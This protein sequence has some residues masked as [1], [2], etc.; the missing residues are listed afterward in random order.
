MKAEFEQT[1]A[2]LKQR[3]SQRPR[4]FTFFNRELISSNIAA[5]DDSKKTVYLSGY[6]FPTE[7]LWAFD[8]QPFDF[9][10][11]CNNLPSALSGQGSAVMK[12]AEAAGYSRAITATV[13][14]KQMK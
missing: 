2:I 10:I 3:H 9:E 7:F 1:L 8:V 14:P 13:R 4:G 11:A 6:E 12:I 5:F